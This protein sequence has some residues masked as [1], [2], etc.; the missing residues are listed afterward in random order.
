MTT[1][2]TTSQA[3]S[4]SAAPTV[5][6]VHD[7]IAAERPAH[8]PL[9]AHQLELDGRLAFVQ[10]WGPADGVPILIDFANRVEYHFPSQP[11][12]SAGFSLHDGKLFYT[13]PADDGQ[14]LRLFYFDFETQT[15]QPVPEFF[16]D[17]VISEET[18][19]WFV[20][21]PRQDGDALP[22]YYRV[23]KSDYFVGNPALIEMGELSL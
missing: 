9:R 13:R 10:D 23:L 14:S 2:T 4:A 22:T 18:E 16:Q 8:T 17:Y 3:A 20:L 1:M 21:F 6:V 11:A 7:P 15:E 5:A 12:S 19:N